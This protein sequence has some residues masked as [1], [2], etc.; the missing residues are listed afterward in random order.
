ML[1]FLALPAAGDG[2][3]EICDEFII[4]DWL[5]SKI[6]ASEEELVKERDCVGHLI[7]NA[8]AACA[9]RGTADTTVP[10]ER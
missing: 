7:G 3:Y 5:R 1:L 8:A 2:D 4:D 6:R 9:I 10:G